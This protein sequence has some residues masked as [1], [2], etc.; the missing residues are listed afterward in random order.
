MPTTYL[1]ISAELELF[2]QDKNAQDV[3]HS[4][5][6]LVP[7][8]LLLSYQ[9]GPGITKEHGQQKYDIYIYLNDF[10]KNSKISFT[11]RVKNSLSISIHGTCKFTPKADLYEF[12]KLDEQPFFLFVSLMEGSSYAYFQA[13]KTGSAVPIDCIWS[14][15]KP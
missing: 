7:E 11:K 2:P 3:L 5:E 6:E 15:K 13:N 10:L 12:L 14:A 8:Q 9:S 1:Q 4:K